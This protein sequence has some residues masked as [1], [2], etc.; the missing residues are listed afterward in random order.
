[1]PIMCT[2]QLPEG[3]KPEQ[4]EAT[5]RDIS[6][7]LIRNFEVQ[8][9]QVRVTIDELPRNRYIAGGVMAYDMPEFNEDD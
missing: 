4:I 1:M 5:L 3:K 9:A 8:P 6:D 2:V 7:V